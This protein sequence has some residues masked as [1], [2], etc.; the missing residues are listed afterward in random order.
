MIHQTFSFFCLVSEPSGK[1]DRWSSSVQAIWCWFFDQSEI[2]RR[3]WKKG[4]TW[5]WGQEF[6]FQCRWQISV[7]CVRWTWWHACVRFYCA[8]SS[9]RALA[10]PADRF[11]HT[12]KCLCSLFTPRLSYQ[13]ISCRSINFFICG[14]ILCCYLSNK[15][16][17]AERLPSSIYFL[18]F[19]K[20]EFHFLKLFCHRF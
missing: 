8:T 20:N 11:V 19:Y 17:M 1:L 4:R 16:L 14:K 6:S 10:R 9:C 7:W 15:I 3:W 18:G 2:Q 13:E 12:V 5:V